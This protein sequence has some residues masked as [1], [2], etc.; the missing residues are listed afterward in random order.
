MGLDDEVV[1]RRRRCRGAVVYEREILLVKHMNRR[2][3][4]VYWWL[5]GG[6]PEPGETEAECV[7]REVK[8]E[9]NLDVSVGRLLCIHRDQAV[10]LCTPVSEEERV[11]SERGSIS[12][13]GLA[14]YPLDDES[15]W[16][17]GFY[18]DHIHPMLRAVQESQSLA[19]RSR[20]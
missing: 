9:T 20:G 4:N 2:T 1:P 7:A 12:L 16:E 6:G 13:L 17:P 8:E 5:P 3:G 19:E 10:Y 11:G 15:S 18:E 14:W